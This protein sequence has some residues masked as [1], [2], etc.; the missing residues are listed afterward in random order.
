MDE[1]DLL[2]MLYLLYGMSLYSYRSPK[3]TEYMIIM[4]WTRPRFW[5]NQ[6]EHRNVEVSKYGNGG[7]MER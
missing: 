2:I 3:M 5:N 7:E 4:P 1:S 6:A